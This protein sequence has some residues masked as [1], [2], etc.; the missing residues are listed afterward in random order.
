M[1]HKWTI[2]IFIISNNKMSYNYC[3]WEVVFFTFLIFIILILRKNG[4]YCFSYI[5]AT[6]TSVL[7]KKSKYRRTAVSQDRFHPHF[8]YSRSFVI[9]ICGF[10]SSIHEYLIVLH[11]LVQCLRRTSKLL[12]ETYRMVGGNKSLSLLCFSGLKLCTLF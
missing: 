8:V 1:T 3:D 12:D 4:R 6:P 9:I 7:G 2:E 10:V 11:Y 5:I